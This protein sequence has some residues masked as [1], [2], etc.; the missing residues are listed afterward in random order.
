MPQYTGFMFDKH[1]DYGIAEW[2]KR[3]PAY[4]KPSHKGNGK[5]QGI[6]A[7]TLT[8]ST[9]D[10]T[11]EEEMVA[12]MKKILNQKTVPVKR[13]A[14]YLEHTENGTPHIHFIYETDTGGRIHQKIFRRYWKV[15]DESTKCGRGHRGG[16]HKVVESET[17]YTEYIAKDGGRGQNN[18]STGQE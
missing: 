3:C 5:P 15:W 13:W 17:A 4:T 16:Y 11:N 6:F 9:S 2:H 8:M 14:W 12:A 1:W 7:G 10:T 18:W